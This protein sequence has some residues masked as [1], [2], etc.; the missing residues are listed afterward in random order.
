[1]L[2]ANKHDSL[3]PALDMDEDTVVDQQVNFII[4]FSLPGN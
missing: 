2:D 4:H 1:L 3:S